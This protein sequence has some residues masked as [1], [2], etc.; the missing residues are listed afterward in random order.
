M[1]PL[2]ASAVPTGENLSHIDADPTHGPIT[3]SC[4]QTTPR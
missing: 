1:T 2:A 3:A 4:V